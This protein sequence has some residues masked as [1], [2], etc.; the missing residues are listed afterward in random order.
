MGKCKLLLSGQSHSSQNDSNGDKICRAASWRKTD[1][2]FA[3]G[4][5]RGRVGATCGKH[6]TSR[7]GV[8]D[9]SWHDAVPPVRLPALGPAR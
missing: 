8:K 1:L 6:D 7:S 4:G 9:P 5:G 3:L 2:D